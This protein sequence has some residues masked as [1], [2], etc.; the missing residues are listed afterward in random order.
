[1]DTTNS[2]TNPYLFGGMNE[3]PNRLPTSAS[4]AFVTLQQAFIAL[5]GGQSITSRFPAGPSGSSTATVFPG[6]RGNQGSLSGMIVSEQDRSTMTG[7]LDGPG[8]QDAGGVIAVTPCGRYRLV[9]V[10]D[11]VTSTRALEVQTVE[12]QKALF[13][14]GRLMVDRSSNVNH[15]NIKESVF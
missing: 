2:R 14:V 9:K 15:G 12:N 1:F 13:R 5:G 11:D 4:G 6:S 7:G 3:V 10:R 8:R